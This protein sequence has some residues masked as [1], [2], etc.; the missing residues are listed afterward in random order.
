MVGCS[1]ALCRKLLLCVTRL[2]A[3]VH[4]I[5]MYDVTHVIA[6]W[7]LCIGTWLVWFAEH[8]WV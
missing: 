7:V 4:S 8:P 5:H 3:V 2:W 6:A 1:L